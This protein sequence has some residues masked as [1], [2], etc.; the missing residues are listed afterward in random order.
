[1]NELFSDWS[2]AEV[3]H[4]K[5]AGLKSEINAWDGNQLLNT[6]IDD[7]CKYFVKKCW[8]D[9]PILNTIPSPK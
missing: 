8:V 6:S 3:E 1:M 9:I 4:R 7:L 2:W 5:R